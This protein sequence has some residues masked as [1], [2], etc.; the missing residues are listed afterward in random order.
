M[1]RASLSVLALLLPAFS[2]AAQTSPELQPPFKVLSGDAPIDVRVGHAAPFVGDLDGDG[3]AD[4]L[5]GQFG[6]GRLRVYRNLGGKEKPRFDGFE[7]LQAGG[8]TG[9]VPSG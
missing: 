4:L 9:T 6:S 7:L 2:A 8:T 5:V 1:L 3:R